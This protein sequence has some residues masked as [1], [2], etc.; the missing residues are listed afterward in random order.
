MTFFSKKALSQDHNTEI[1]LSRK[2]KTKHKRFVILLS[3]FIKWELWFY[4]IPVTCFNQM[5]IF[6]RS[7]GWREMC[8]LASSES[9]DSIGQQRQPA[10]GQTVGS[11]DGQQFGYSVRFWLS[12]PKSW[13]CFFF[14]PFRKKLGDLV[15]KMIIWSI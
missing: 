9:F 15:Y 3:H 4:N 1:S 2:L 10:T 7:W 12:W 13:C 6:S 8:R 14:F 5:Y 11:K